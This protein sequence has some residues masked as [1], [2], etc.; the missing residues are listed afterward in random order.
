[1]SEDESVDVRQ[2]VAGLVDHQRV[3]QRAKADTAFAQRLGAQLGSI[4]S[5]LHLA[6][7]RHDDVEWLPTALEW[8]QSRDDL[9]CA[10]TRV[11]NDSALV[12]Q[13]DRL[14]QWFESLPVS[15]GDLTLVHGDI[16]FHNLVFDPDT[17]EVRGLID[18]KDAVSADRH[19]DFRYLM[20]D[21]GR[22]DLLDAACDVYA[23]R[24]GRHID[25]GRVLLYNAVWAISFLAF[26]DGVSPTAL[27]CGRT[28]AGDLGWCRAALAL[29]LGEHDV[30]HSI[31]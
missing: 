11:A 18:F 30:P 21:V 9:L 24:T 31:Q 20:F 26:R 27:S 14:L 8:P 28:L 13:A 7:T 3:F 10:I 5:E 16:G 19:L 2:M 22:F 25:R 12:H 17:L 23:Q 4:L 29:A 6:V 1:V 15:A